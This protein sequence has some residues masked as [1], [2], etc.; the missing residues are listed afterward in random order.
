MAAAAVVPVL[1]A[2]VALCQSTD[3]TG[4]DGSSWSDPGNWDNGVPSQ[5]SEDVNIISGSTATVDYDYTGPTVSLGTLSLDNTNGGTETVQISTNNIALNDA[6]VGVNGNGAFIQS[7][8]SLTLETF[9]SMELGANAGSTGSYVLSGS[10]SLSGS[11]DVG[12]NGCGVFNQSGGSNTEE[13]LELGA[14]GGSSGTYLLSGSGVLT[15]DVMSVGMSSGSTA[16]FSQ[17]GGTFTLNNQIIVGGASGAT[18]IFNLSGGVISTPTVGEEFVGYRGDGVFNQTGGTNIVG[19]PTQTEDDVDVGFGSGSNG[20]FNLSGGE[21]IDYGFLQLGS[22]GTGIFTVSNQGELV[23]KANVYVQ[24]HG[25]FVIS[26]GCAIIGG[27]DFSSIGGG[28]LANINS[29]LMIDPRYPFATSDGAIQGYIKSGQIIGTYAAANGLYIA[30]AGGSDPGVIDPNLLPG[31]FVVEPDIAG[32]ADMNGVVNFHDLQMLLAN[33]GNLGYWDQGNFNNHPTIDFDDLQ[34]L[35][36]NFS[37]SKTL[38]DSELAGIED[39]VGQ[40]GYIA[41]ANGDNNGFSL[42]AVPEPASLGLLAVGATL[43]AARRRGCSSP[44]SCAW[45]PGTRR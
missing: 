41:D 13:Q 12:E 9:S 2:G 40:F 21:L 27:L 23:V 22:G 11:V 6:Y 25:E 14:G 1:F 31:E 39:L 28:G 26:G 15:A 10:G 43:L 29:A 18:G 8:G 38:S 19:S 42:V 36:G 30:Y 16:S 4:S 24:P 17:S 33:F 3:W 7:G 5:S 20:V 35:L 32:D 37:D 44:C 45:R 34:M